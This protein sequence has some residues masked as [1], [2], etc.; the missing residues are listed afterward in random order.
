MQHKAKYVYFER[1]SWLHYL[2]SVLYK[3][4]LEQR[5]WSCV[6]LLWLDSLDGFQ[7]LLYSE[8]SFVICGGYT[9]PLGGHSPKLK[10]PE[11]I[12]T[13]RIVILQAYYGWWVSCYIGFFFNIL[14]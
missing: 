12:G 4:K 8:K 7:F 11:N 1:V 3:Q 10:D 2:P 9:P 5:T 13:I 14:Q 6:N